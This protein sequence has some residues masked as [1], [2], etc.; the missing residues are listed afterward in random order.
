VYWL[1]A[2]NDECGVTK[3]ADYVEVRDDTGAIDVNNSVGSNSNLWK[4]EQYQGPVVDVTVSSIAPTLSD[5]GEV[6]NGATHSS[7]VIGGSVDGRRSNKKG[8]FKLTVTAASG[9]AIKIDRQPK[10]KDACVFVDRAIGAATPGSYTLVTEGEDIWSGTARSTNNVGGSGGGT[11]TTFDMAVDIGSPA[12]WAIG[13]RVTG[14][15]A[16]AAKTGSDAVYVTAI[17]V[18]TGGGADA[19]KITLS[20]SVTIANGTALTFTPPQYHRWTTTNIVGLVEGS[21]VKNSTYGSNDAYIAPWKA[22]E[23]RT[24]VT[25]DGCNEYRNTIDV[26]KG[27]H[28]SITP[29]GSATATAYGRIT[30]RPGQII[31]SS[32]HTKAFEST[33]HRFYS[34]GERKIAQTMRSESVRLTNLK[35]EIETDNIITTTISDASAD[36]STA[37]NDFDVASINGIMDDVSV[38]SGPNITISGGEPTVTTISSA[39]VTLTPGGHY[40]Q[41][42][43]TLTFSGAA[44]VVTITGNIEINDIGDASTT[45]Y[46]DVEKFLTCA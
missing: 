12:K 34:Y 39:N 43:Q 32:P 10:S 14:N 36:G 45:I 2:I 29:T 33:T 30:E 38:V 3:F 4:K 17:N 13:D 35:A 25:V 27:T 28:P 46:L 26:I 1:F 42:G 9:K 18:D 23:T 16:L 15:V 37:L 11:G 40:V 21:I 8:Y 19:S 24:I 31:F 6:W 5:G 7:Q 44:S 20:E 41:N 22:T